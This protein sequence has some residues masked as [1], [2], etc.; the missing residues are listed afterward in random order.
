MIGGIDGTNYLSTNLEFSLFV[1]DEI[2]MFTYEI[3]FVTDERIIFRSEIAF[4]MNETDSTV[5]IRWN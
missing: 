5:Y 1:I 4:F 3:N 2:K